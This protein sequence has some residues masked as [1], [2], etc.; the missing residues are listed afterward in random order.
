VG[1]LFSHLRKT[2]VSV[3]G[4]DLHPALVRVAARENALEGRLCA[5][6]ILNIPFPNRSHRHVVAMD[7]VEHLEDPRRALREMAR[8]LGADGLV[9]LS[10]PNRFFECLYALF[11]VKQEDVGHQRTY[12]KNDLER[13]I[14]GSGLE[15]VSHTTACNPLAGLA[16]VF[17]ARLAILLFGRETVRSSEMAL[18]GSSNGWLA[19]VY[20]LACHAYYPFSVVLEWILPS[21]WGVEN[22]VVLRRVEGP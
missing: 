1:I 16:D 8:V 3:T 10:V 21:S 15:V 19:W 5:G 9:F 22:F 2:G 12:S 14:D 11:G 4:F 6:S 13:L 17:I 18:R 7:V 20:Y